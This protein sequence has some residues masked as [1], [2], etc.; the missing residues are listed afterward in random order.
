MIQRFYGYSAAAPP[1]SS[2]VTQQWAWRM[3]APALVALPSASFDRVIVAHAL[4]VVETGSF[5]VHGHAAL[6][7]EAAR[8][9][10]PGGSLLL[11]ELDQHDSIELRETILAAVAEEAA[12]VAAAA[13][14]GGITSSA[15]NAGQDA[16]QDAG[17]A[18]TATARQQR[19][20]WRQRLGPL[21]PGFVTPRHAI[22]LLER[23]GLRS[24]QR[25][26]L[27]DVAAAVGAP[28]AGANYTEALGAA[29]RDRSAFV[30][31]GVKP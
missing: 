4:A 26:A 21:E 17:A 25:L 31:Q 7:R 3:G 1:V 5:G 30:L 22:A 28:E 18:G 11:L 13:K 16:G 23:A 29:L 6:L 19:G 24:V 8:L 12:A 9:L 2:A 27:S 20:G 10:R 15:G 14:G